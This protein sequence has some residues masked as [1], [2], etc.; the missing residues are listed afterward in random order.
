M[1]FKAKLNLK[2]YIAS[3]ILLGMVVFG[4]YGLYFLNAN[5]ILM[6]D[7]APMD[8]QTKLTFSIIIGS[9]VLSWSISFL[10]LVRQIIHGQAFS[11]NK[12][13]I[14]YT[15]TA[16]NVLAFI[17]IIPIKTIPYDAIEKIYEEDG[18]LTLFI[19]KNKVDMI[20]ALRVFARKRYHLFSGFT[21]ENQEKIKE[22][23]DKYILH[24]NN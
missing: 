15:C 24:I 11:I 7:N 8:S 12:D 22:E 9:V 19:D 6:E 14:H 1:E 23:L 20:S 4:W 16:I 10:T 5:E 21:E 17:F 3:V 2:F 13:G 18:I